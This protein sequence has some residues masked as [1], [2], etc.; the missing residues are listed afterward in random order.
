MMQK[1]LYIINE[2]EKKGKKEEAHKRLRAQYYL[3]KYCPYCGE[4]L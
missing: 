3:F 1:G 2:L 4:R